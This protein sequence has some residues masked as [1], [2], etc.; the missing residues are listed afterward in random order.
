MENIFLGIFSLQ[1]TAAVAASKFWKEKK[2]W[3]LG[4]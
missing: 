1:S 2:T 3:L 4:D